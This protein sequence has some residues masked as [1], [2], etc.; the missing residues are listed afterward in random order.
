LCSARWGWVLSVGI[1]FYTLGLGPTCWC[2]DLCGSMLG[3]PHSP[4][5]VIVALWSYL[6]RHPHT[7][8]SALRSSHLHLCVFRHIG[9]G[10]DPRTFVSV[11][12]SCRPSLDHTLLRWIALSFVR[13]AVGGLV[14]G[15]CVVRRVGVFEML[16]LT[17]GTTF[18]FAP[19]C[20]SGCSGWVGDVGAGVKNPE[21]ASLLSNP[22][23]GWLMG[24][25]SWA[26]GA[27]YRRWALRVVV[28]QC[29]WSVGGVYPP[30]A[31]P[32]VGGYCGGLLTKEDGRECTSWAS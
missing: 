27:G 26:L 2:G 11:V 16:A 13:T 24:A 7:D 9:I 1:G 31:V 12:G 25:V 6:R 29:A 10:F 18:V 23:C 28:G 17:A 15:P 30:W 32:G 5:A 3:R 4:L 22:P 21:P 8:A 20:S 19:S 14:V